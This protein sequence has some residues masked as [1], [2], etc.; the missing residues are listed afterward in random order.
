MSDDAQKLRLRSRVDA[1]DSALSANSIESKPDHGGV[2]ASRYPDGMQGDAA[3]TPPRSQ[4]DLAADD[5]AGLARQIGIPVAGRP[6]NSPTDLPPIATPLP[7]ATQGAQ[8]AVLVLGI[9]VIIIFVAACFLAYRLFVSSEGTAFRNDLA[10]LPPAVSLSDPTPKASSGKP[11]GLPQYSEIPA[12][13]PTAPDQPE[14]ASDSLTR[15]STEDA[16][17]A[18]RKWV[19]NV[20]ISGVRVSSNPRILIGKVSFN[21]GDVVDEK[22]G[23]IFVGYDRERYVVRFQDSSG[24]ILERQDRVLVPINAPPTTTPR[25]PSR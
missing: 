15:A 24:A 6:Q 8:R 10:V 18:F 1:N 11:A 3:G 7:P 4:S 17:S 12:P 19:E 2:E 22:L 23:I 9:A 21:Q 14:L 13:A 16:P 25:Q 5:R 20:R